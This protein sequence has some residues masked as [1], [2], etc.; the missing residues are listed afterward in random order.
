MSF[1]T[2]DQ[3]IHEIEKKRN[4]AIETLSNKYIIFKNKSYVKQHW[5]SLSEEEKKEYWNWA[6]CSKEA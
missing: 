5:R 2:S 1:F 3:N 6:R 4:K